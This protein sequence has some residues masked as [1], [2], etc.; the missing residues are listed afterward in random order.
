MNLDGNQRTD[1]NNET[2]LYIDH[3]LAGYLI[4][5]VGLLISV[6]IFVTERC[7]SKKD[8]DIDQTTSMTK[9]MY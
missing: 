1:D 6:V 9:V 7:C 5:S 4:L 2:P 8:S 3:F